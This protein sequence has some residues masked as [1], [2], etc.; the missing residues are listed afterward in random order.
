VE[1]V[2]LTVVCEK[3]KCKNIQYVSPVLDPLYTGTILRS[4][5][6]SG[7]ECY[8]PIIIRYKFVD[9]IPEVDHF[10]A[11]SDVF[12]ERE[13]PTGITIKPRARSGR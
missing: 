8:T 4:F 10:I 2:P 11:V 1:L 12:I 7:W 6:C 13:Q 5:Y 9:G 3:C